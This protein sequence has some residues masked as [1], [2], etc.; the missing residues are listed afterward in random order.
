MSIDFLNSYPATAIIAMKTSFVIGAVLLSLF[1]VIHANTCE[2]SESANV[3]C[4]ADEVNACYDEFYYA[5]NSAELFNVTDI[6][7]DALIEFLE[8]VSTH[9]QY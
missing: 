5:C 2:L 8:A 9:C 4:I 3:T 1:T 7:V 6:D